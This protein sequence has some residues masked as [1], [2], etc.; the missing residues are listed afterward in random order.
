MIQVKFSSDE[1]FVAVTASIY[2]AL[3]FLFI[4][5]LLDIASTYY[6]LSLPFVVE[7]NPFMLAVIG[8]VGFFGAVIVKM[9]ITCTAIL[10]VHQAL[11]F[12]AGL[13]KGR[14]WRAVGVS[15]ILVG[16]GAALLNLIMIVF[17][18]A[19]VIAGA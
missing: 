12:Y 8:S 6:G 3:K 13:K 4:F 14:G 17:G 11:L 19:I 2:T 16:V 5:N 9:L 10:F 1:Y 7:S 15:I 18:N